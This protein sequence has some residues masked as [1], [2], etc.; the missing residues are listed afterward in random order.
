MNG[1]ARSSAVPDTT[2][3]PAADTTAFDRTLAAHH[4]A[5]FWTARVPS[6]RAEPAFLWKWAPLEQALERAGRDIG[7]AMAERRVIKLSN[8]QLPSGAASR[9]VQFNFSIVNGGERAVAHRHSIGAVRFVLRGHAAYT[10]VDGARCDMQPGDFILTPAGSWHDHTN[11]S[12]EPVVWLDGLDGPLIQALNLAFF[13]DHMHAEQAV[14]RMAGPPLRVAREAA[15]AALDAMAPADEDPDLGACFE[16]PALPT[17]ACRLLRQRGG[18]PRREHRR[19]SATLFHVVE[20]RGHTTVGEQTLEWARGDTF[21]VPAWNW[22]R[23]AGGGSGKDG[24]GDA[25]LFSMD[26]SPALRALGLY[27]EET[28]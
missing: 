1:V 18:R 2:A 26:D 17:L 6:H 5:G 8:P 24:S 14:E 3:H 25:L 21:V 7:M 28:R 4:L 15:V 23:H 20:G 19:S 27:K 16:Y 12:G 13:E 9:T 10:T 11:L 22:C